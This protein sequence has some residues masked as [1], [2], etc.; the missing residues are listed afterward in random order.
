MNFLLIINGIPI[1]PALPV[2]SVPFRGEFPSNKIAELREAEQVWLTFPS[3]SGVN[4]LLMSRA[5]ERVRKII[6]VSVPFRGEFPS[7]EYE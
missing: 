2:V 6:I 3:P 5:Y 7:N 1:T 4:F